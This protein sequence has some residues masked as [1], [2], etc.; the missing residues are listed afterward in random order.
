MFDAFYQRFLLRDL[1]GRVIPGL[2]VILVLGVTAGGITATLNLINMLSVGEWL[3]VI[4][5][6]WIAG[7]AIVSLGEI[8]RLIMYYPRRRCLYRFFVTHKMERWSVS[9]LKQMH[10]VKQL[11]TLLWP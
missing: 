5:F 4:G 9:R 2:A 1:F 11:Q 6:G 7:F 3:V 10:D 8:L